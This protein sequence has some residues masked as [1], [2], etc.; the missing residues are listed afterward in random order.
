MLSFLL[1]IIPFDLIQITVA[2]ESLNLAA[3]F[4]GRASQT[5]VA[6]TAACHTCEFEQFQLFGVGAVLHIFGHQLGSKPV[7][8]QLQDAVSVCDRTFTN[9]E[10]VAYFERPARLELYAGHSD[11]SVLAGVGGDG[12]G[13]VYPHRPEIFIY[14][15]FCHNLCTL[16]L[17]PSSFV[18]ELV[19]RSVNTGEA[20]GGDNFGRYFEPLLQCF[21]LFVSPFTEHEIDLGAAGELIAD[22]KPYARVVLGAQDGLDVSEPVMTAVGTLFADADGAERQV[23]VIDEDEHILHRYLL[24]LEPITHGIAGEVHIGGGFEE[25]EFGVLD[26][27]FGDE[28]VAFV[29]PFRFH[30][31]SKR[32]DYHETDVMTSTGVLIADITKSDNKEFHV[33]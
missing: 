7:L 21:L 17:V 9:R 4:L 25:H 23:E 3:V 2:H 24:L 27:A 14:S 8:G 11:T 10:Y 12:A 32:I 13:L 6:H 15:Y 5:S 26:T 31:C 29:L 33:Y 16:Y 28:A 18:I 1:L 20:E 19:H 22:A 30:G